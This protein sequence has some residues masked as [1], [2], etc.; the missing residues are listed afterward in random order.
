MLPDFI[1]GFGDASI[2]PFPVDDVAA[3]TEQIDETQKI[4]DEI[5]SAATASAETEL[6]EIEGICADIQ[7]TLCGEVGVS[8]NLLEGIVSKIQGKMTTDAVNSM[9]AIYTDMNLLGLSIPTQTDIEYANATGDYI[10]SVT[11]STPAVG[12][13]DSVPIESEASQGLVPTGTTGQDAE[14]KATPVSPVAQPPASVTRDLPPGSCRE[15]VGEPGSTHPGSYGALEACNNTSHCAVEVTSWYEELT[16]NTIAAYQAIAGGFGGGAVRPVE[17]NAINMNLLGD[18]NFQVQN[19]QSWSS[20][21]GGWWVQ[22]NGPIGSYNGPSGILLIPVGYH[23]QIDPTTGVVWAV[24]FNRPDWCGLP[25]YGTP[26]EPVDP[27]AQQPPDG[28][29]QACTPVCPPKNAPAC[30]ANVAKIKPPE[31][32]EAENWCNL[33]QRMVEAWE[34]MT[35]T[36]GNMF[37]MGSA[38]TCGSGI[39]EQVAAAIAGSGGPV[40]PSFVNG[41]GTWATAKVKELINSANCNAGALL[42]YALWRAAFAFL[43]KWVG[44]VPPQ[45]MVLVEQMGNTICQMELPGVPDADRAYMHGKISQDI[46]E[47]WVKA[48]GHKTDEAKLVRDSGRV[49]PDPLQVSQLFRREEISQ[50]DFLTRMRENGVIDDSDKDQI[51]N[52]TKSWPGISDVIRMMVRDAADKEAVERGKLDEDFEKKWADKLKKYG[53]AIGVTEELARYYWRSHWELPSYTQAQLMLFR[54]NDDQLP[55]NLKFDV[56]KMRDLLKQDDHAPGYVDRL[57]EIAYHP[58]NTSDA[59]K[60]YYIYASDD[61][62]FRKQLMHQ[63]YKADNAD[64]MVQ[65]HKKVR[66]INDKRRAGYPSLASLAQSY[67]RCEIDNGTFRNVVAGLAYSEEHERF[68]VEAANVRKKITDNKLLIKAVRRP[69]MLGIIDQSEAISKLSDGGID[70]G[71]VQGLVEKWE[72]ERMKRDKYASAAQLCKWRENALIGAGEQLKALIKMGWTRE[73]ALR[74]VTQCGLEIEVRATQKMERQAAKA[75]A[76]AEKARKEAEKL[77]RQAECGPPPC[78][79]NRRQSNRPAPGAGQGS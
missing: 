58:I 34:K 49:K 2:P 15:N 74:I 67:A 13:N 75:A 54:L 53:D 29:G 63:G 43:D 59:I 28:G 50:E 31:M 52:L 39:G 8:V 56:Q 72:I 10:G 42:P 6:V 3:V 57:I 25:Q 45:L 22:I 41:L 4:A 21:T 35:E 79:A 46:W 30:P 1:P 77:R 64:F 38:K 68:I 37:G 47:C 36:G 44:A 71:C 73:D 40:I 7:S 14:P 51:H 27:T 69:F 65:Y 20:N 62:T 24:K 55:E 33:L 19:A 16:P 61:A 11:G 23:L 12:R 76:A 9:E 48:A 70:S 66:E 26:E 5:A 18:G 32:S 17:Y 78:P 60:A